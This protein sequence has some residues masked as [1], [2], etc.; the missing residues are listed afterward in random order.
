[1]KTSGAEELPPTKSQATVQ[2]PTMSHPTKSVADVE[3][4]SDL[5]SGSDYIADD[6]IEYDY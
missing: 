4:L 3:D 6:E 5:G 1:L 2:S